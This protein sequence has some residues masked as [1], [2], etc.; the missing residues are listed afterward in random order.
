MYEEIHIVWHIC[1]TFSKLILWI[2]NIYFQEESI[3]SSSVCER[4]SNCSKTS[5]AAVVPWQALQRCDITS[6]IAANASYSTDE[7]EK[8]MSK[9]EEIK[10]TIIY[11]SA[12][13]PSFSFA[14][15]RDNKV[16]MR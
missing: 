2:S 5:S 16:R 11:R 6:A 15:F 3:S 7:V 4:T 9:K 14:K 13:E 12:E 8:V 1:G 10:G